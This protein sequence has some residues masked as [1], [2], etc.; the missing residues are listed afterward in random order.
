MKNFLNKESKKLLYNF[1]IENKKKFIKKKNYSSISDTEIKGNVLDGEVDISSNEYKSNFESMT[2]Y[3]DELKNIV[4][5]VKLGGGQEAIKR[6]LSKKKML[7][8]DRIEKLL[9]NGSY[10]LELSQTAGYKLYDEGIKL[11]NISR[12]SF[13][14]Y[15]HRFNYNCKN[16]YNFII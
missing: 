13:W 11:F 5:K 3:I 7:P 12:C 9:D 2:Q 4:N 8:R 10:F 15:N 14:W 6:Q 1:F 16:I